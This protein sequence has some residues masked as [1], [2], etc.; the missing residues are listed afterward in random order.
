MVLATVCFFQYAARNFDKIPALQLNQKTVIV[1]LFSIILALSNISIAGLIWQLLLIDNH[2]RIS[3]KQTQIIF[4]IAQFGKYLPGNVGQ[5]MGR[6]FMAQEIGIPASITLST[7]MVETIWVAAVGGSLGV[8][9]L[10]I[11]GDSQIPGFQF[12]LRP[13]N[14][15]LLFAFLFFIPWVSLVLLNR[16][17]PRLIKRFSKVGMITTPRFFTMIVV[18]A[19]LCL[20]FGIMGLILKLQAQW[21]FGVPGA[22]LLK[23]TGLFAIAWLA[24]YLLPGAPG[25]L[26]MREAMMVLLFS[27]VLGGGAA[28]GLGV[29]HRMTTI[30]G[31]G[32]A[33][34]FG[35][36][37]KRI[38]LPKRDSIF[39]AK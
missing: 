37:F 12:E 3:W 6:V 18:T 9:S 7:I 27:P 5:Y 34:L 22:G 24:G 17:L 14:L 33:F 36:I 31:D 29:T 19:L 30:T 25:G 20:C 23:M 15:L 28:V 8:L 2:V 10:F 35:I 1:A 21:F 16:C 26:G 11:F 32:L 39:S 4:V 13:F 38:F